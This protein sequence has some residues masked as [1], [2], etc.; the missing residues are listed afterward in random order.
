MT[1]EVWRVGRSIGEN[2]PDEICAVQRLAMHL[3]S[4]IKL[5]SQTYRCN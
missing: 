4:T 3:V 2:G 5:M 1:G